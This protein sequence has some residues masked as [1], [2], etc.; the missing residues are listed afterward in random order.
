MAWLETFTVVVTQAHIAK[1]ST[2][3]LEKTPLALAI[4]DAGWYWA[5]ANTGNA[6]I[7]N[8]WGDRRYCVLP[9]EARRFAA[10]FNAGGKVEPF[11]FELQGVESPLTTGGRHSG[12][13][14]VPAR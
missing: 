3:D 6:Y 5:S 12:K 7:E 11:V 8:Y 2:E 10:D 14:P 4:R 9:D 13:W 1:G